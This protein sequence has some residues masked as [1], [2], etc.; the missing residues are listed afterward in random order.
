MDWGGQGEEERGN[1]DSPSLRQQV[2][3]TEV[4]LPR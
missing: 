2:G 3:E 4:R 1:K